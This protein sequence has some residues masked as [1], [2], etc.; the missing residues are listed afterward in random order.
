MLDLVLETSGR[1][2]DAH[3]RQL[4]TVRQRT[5]EELETLMTSIAAV[6]ESTTQLNHQLVGVSSI[7][8][9]QH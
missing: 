2:A 3:E 5:S 1:I 4:E 6:A 8:S 9:G 7:Q